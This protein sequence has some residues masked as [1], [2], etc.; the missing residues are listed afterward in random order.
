MV[1]SYNEGD[2]LGKG[3]A[4]QNMTGEMDPLV[5]AK[6]AMLKFGDDV[7]KRGAK[8]IAVVVDEK[9]KARYKVEELVA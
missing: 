1:L 2:P 6:R 5:I 7:R 9:E 3:V 4:A 8:W